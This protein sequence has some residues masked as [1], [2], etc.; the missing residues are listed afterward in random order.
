ME[1]ENK[2]IFAGAKKEFDSDLTFGRQGGDGD[3]LVGFVSLYRSLRHFV[4]PWYLGLCI[5]TL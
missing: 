4:R 1:E 3:L 2:A 5:S